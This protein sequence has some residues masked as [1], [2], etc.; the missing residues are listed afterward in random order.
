[1]VSEETKII[2]FDGVCNF[3]NWAVN[4]IIKR[5]K[6]GIFKFTAS[7]SNTGKKILAGFNIED[8]GEKSI[9]LI[10]RDKYLTRSD[11]VLEILRYL[12]SGWQF[13]KYLKIFPRKLRD[14]GYS[15]F[16]RY[17]YNIFGK[18]DSCMIPPDDLKGRFLN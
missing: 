17:R 14:W 16:S 7:Q 15:V 13:T 8:I 5:D 4:F 3:C 12:G 11:A 10:D 1:M 6:S 18:R 2:V 9:I